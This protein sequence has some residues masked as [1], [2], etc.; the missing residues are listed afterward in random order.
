MYALF[1]FSPVAFCISTTDEPSYY[2]RVNSAYL[3]LFG[4]EWSEIEGQPISLHMASSPDS[5]ARM[6]RMH[7]LAT[8]G[9]YELEEVDLRHT[10]GHIVPTLISA[11]R[12][13]VGGASVD[14]EIIVDNTDRK[15]LEN[16]IRQA[17]HTDSLTQV[18]NR[19]GFEGLL[20]RAIETKSPTEAI[21]LAYIDLNGF[22]AINDQQGHAVGDAVLRIVGQRLGEAIRGNGQVGR[23]GGDEF[24]ILFHVPD[25]DLPK[26]E[27]FED[28]AEAL[29]QPIVLGDSV[30][31][32]GLSMG[33]AVMDAP[34]NLDHLLNQADDLMY[35]AKAGGGPIAIRLV[36]FSAPDETNTA[37]R[38]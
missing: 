6:R 33:V 29:C 5:P 16:A 12:C 20:A 2:V 19:A 27:R 21:G 3:R 15:A 14:I 35:E 26:Q 23:L 37:D 7:Q 24:A 1:E 31:N 17:A 34:R 30:L 28:L 8:V 4:R 11:H 36:H 18:A 9:F 25:S 32:I 22:K 38:G 13:V 10:S